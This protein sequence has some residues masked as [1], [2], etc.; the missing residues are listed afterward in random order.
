M[1]IQLHRGLSSV[2][3]SCLPRSPAHTR[4]ADS[5]P[6]FAYIHAA[7]GFAILFAAV[8]MS[9]F[10]SCMTPVEEGIEYWPMYLVVM[11]RLDAV[12]GRIGTR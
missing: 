4:V 12:P 11:W 7:A 3:L 10:S 6:G 8:L 9:Y 5:L 2:L 1:L